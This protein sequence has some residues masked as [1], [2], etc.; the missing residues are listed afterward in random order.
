MWEFRLIELLTY[1]SWPF[2][3]IRLHCLADRKSDVLEQCIR[4][5]HILYGF[6]SGVWAP[7]L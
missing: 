1:Y 4:Y 5:I 2:I 7:N 6:G 3:D